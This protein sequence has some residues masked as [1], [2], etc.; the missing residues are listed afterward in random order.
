MVVLVDHQRLRLRVATRARDKEPVSGADGDDGGLNKRAALV[1][2]N[3][4]AVPHGH[5]IGNIHHILDGVGE[6]VVE[7]EMLEGGAW[8]RVL[9][10][11]TQLQLS[12]S[13]R[14]I[15]LAFAGD[16]RDVRVSIAD[17]ASVAAATTDWLCFIAFL[18]P[19]F[20]ERLEHVKVSISNELEGKEETESMILRIM[21]SHKHLLGV[22]VVVFPPLLLSSSSSSKDDPPGS[23]ADRSSCLYIHAPA[24]THAH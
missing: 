17:V 13:I 11:T 4:P 7:I 5:G 3:D 6:E 18:V 16:G 22:V 21:V 23:L 14:R 15:E 19:S 8:R 24:R 9:L 20:T 12:G 10:H 1:E 2:R